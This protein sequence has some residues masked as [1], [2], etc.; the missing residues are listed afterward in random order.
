MLAPA[1]AHPNATAGCSSI[2][3]AVMR[4]LEQV[5]L[6][7]LVQRRRSTSR[8]SARTGLSTTATSSGSAIAMYVPTV[9]MNWDTSPIHTA[10]GTA[11]GTP[12]T[13]STTKVVSPETSASSSLE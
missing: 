6:D 8:I 5:V 11:N 1:M 12:S 13:V 2:V 4:G 3:L 9:G 10:S 7:L